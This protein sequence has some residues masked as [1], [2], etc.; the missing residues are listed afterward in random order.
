MNGRKSTSRPQCLNPCTN[1]LAPRK[2]TSSGTRLTAITTVSTPATVRTRPVPDSADLNA[3]ALEA[4]SAAR[5]RRARAPSVIYEGEK[6]C[7]EL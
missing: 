3:V 7:R 4:L 2:S 6:V 5:R 1:P